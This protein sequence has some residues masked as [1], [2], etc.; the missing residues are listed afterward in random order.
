MW[1]FC[2]EQS[3]TGAVLLLV[4][5]IDCPFSSHRLFHTNYP[6]S[7]PGKVGGLVAVSLSK[8]TKCANN[9]SK[10]LEARVQC[11]RALSEPYFHCHWLKYLSERYGSLSCKHWKCY[12]PVRVYTGAKSILCFFDNMEEIES[13]ICPLNVQI[14]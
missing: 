13:D 3:G 9:V 12:M 10:P 7:R 5:C 14:V 1:G 4:L 8:Q 11:P 6:S 2:G